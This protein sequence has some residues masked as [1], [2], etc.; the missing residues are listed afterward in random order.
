LH[1]ER[2]VDTAGLGAV[3]GALVLVGVLRLP[4]SQR[5]LVF[6]LLLAAAAGVY[7]GG[8]LGLRHAP[9]LTAEALAFLAFG[10]A[11][12]W[13]ARVPLVL[14]LVWPIHALWDLVHYLEFVH[15]SIPRVYEVACFA[16]D[17]VWGFTILGRPELFL[18]KKSSVHPAPQPPM[19]PDD[20]TP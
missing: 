15:T 5:S 10:A 18:T 11:A 3:L 20:G 4:R 8:A 1:Y 9:T 16:A 19:S 13:G 6:A 2:L 12:F 14:G 7:L 17:V